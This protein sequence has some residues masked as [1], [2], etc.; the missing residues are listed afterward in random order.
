MSVSSALHHLSDLEALGGTARKRHRLVTLG[1]PPPRRLG[2]DCRALREDCEEIVEEIVRDMSL[3]RRSGKGDASETEVLSVS[4]STWLK[5]KLCLDRGASEGLEST[6][7]WIRVI[8]KSP[9]L[10]ENSVSL[11]AHYLFTYNRCD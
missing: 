7:T 9:K 1:L 2:G 6:S 10:W 8:G 4:L 5:I 3:P 11:I